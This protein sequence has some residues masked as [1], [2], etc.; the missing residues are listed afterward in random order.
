MKCRRRKEKSGVCH[1][2]SES[3]TSFLR[4]GSEEGEKEE[5]EEEEE[6]E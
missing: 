6:D 1:G 2:G 3:H 5:E 4:E